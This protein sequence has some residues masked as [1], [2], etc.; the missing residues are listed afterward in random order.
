MIRAEFGADWFTPILQHP[1]CVLRH[2]Q[3][4]T[5]LLVPKPKQAPTPSTSSPARKRAKR[6][7]ASSL[8]SS[9]AG[10]T[11]ESEV[12]YEGVLPPFESFVMFYLGENVREFCHAFR[13]VGLVPG[14][15]SW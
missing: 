5:A 6:G 7:L 9:V 4:P 3:A 15:N 10:G 13:T 8:N 11:G 2:T 1:Y 12:E 14:I